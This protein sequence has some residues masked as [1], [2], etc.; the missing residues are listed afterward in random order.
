MSRCIGTTARGIR[1]PIVKEGDD[2]VSI[3][4]DS[5]L[6]AAKSENFELRDRD[7]VGITESLIARAQGNYATVEHIAKDVSSKFPG[8]RGSFPNFK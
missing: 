4:V 6:K 7:I 3:V 1:T 5:V 2:L 8:Y